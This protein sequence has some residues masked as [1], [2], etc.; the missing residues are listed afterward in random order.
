MHCPNGQ[1][2][3]QIP[4][5]ASSQPMPSNSLSWPLTICH[6]STPYPNPLPGRAP[7]A[8]EEAIL[9]CE[10]VEAVVTLA[11]GADEAAESVDLVVTS[12][13]T[14]LVNLADADLDGSVILGLNDASGSRLG[15]ISIAIRESF[16]VTEG[17]HA[18]AGD[19]N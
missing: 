5:P 2:I 11:H 14:V 9:L 13:A 1:R 12:V 17:T 7:N 3:A 18:F 4:I 15:G 6:A 8:L 16:V 19:V 10:P